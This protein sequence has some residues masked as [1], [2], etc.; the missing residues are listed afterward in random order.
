MEVLAKAD[1]GNE[2]V[3]AVKLGMSNLKRHIYQI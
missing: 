1:L 3:E 2:N